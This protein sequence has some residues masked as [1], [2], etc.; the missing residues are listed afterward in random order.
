M[1]RAQQQQ[2]LAEYKHKSPGVSDVSA[3]GGAAVA[4]ASSWGLSGSPPTSNNNATVNRPQLPDLPA[5]KLNM[6]GQYRSVAL[7]LLQIIMSLSTDHSSFKRV[8]FL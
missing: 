5:F 4:A 6:V 8:S 1:S 2:Q 3:G 7:L